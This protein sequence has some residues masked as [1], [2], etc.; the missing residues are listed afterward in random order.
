MEVYDAPL[1]P[2]RAVAGYGSIFLNTTFLKDMI[3]AMAYSKLNVLHWHA[4]DSQSFPVEVTAF[5]ELSEK[6]AF[7]PKSHFCPDAKCTYSKEDIRDVVAYAEDR[8]VRVLLE[9]DTPGHA[10]EWGK[11]YP[12]MSLSHCS[13]N[14]DSIPLNP[15]LNFTSKVVRGVLQ[16]WLKISRMHT[17]I[18]AAMRSTCNAGRKTRK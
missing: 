16:T 6:A 18:S 3:D 13:F 2:P 17:S 7:P 12:N 8:A 14:A 4:I 5:P 10:K 15:T 11:A 1:S 9:I